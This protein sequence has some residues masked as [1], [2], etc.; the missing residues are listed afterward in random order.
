[1]ASDLAEPPVGLTLM[2]YLEGLVVESSS[3]FGHHST[4]HCEVHQLKLALSPCRLRARL[5]SVLVFELMG[6]AVT[7]HDIERPYC[8]LP[9]EFGFLLEMIN[10]R[11]FHNSTISH[12][13]SW[14]LS[15]EP[16][17]SQNTC[18]LAA[19]LPPQLLRSWLREATLCSAI[20][21]F[22]ATWSSIIARF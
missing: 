13:P 16:L 17:G 21:N 8:L 7:S 12:I 2:E 5:A 19:S 9:S 22:W 11:H 14:N 6:F 20:L 1:M 10:L 18:S 15:F 4:G 3:W